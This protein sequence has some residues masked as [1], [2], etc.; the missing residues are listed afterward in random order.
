[1]GIFGEKQ[2]GNFVFIPK[3]GEKITITIVGEIKRIKN[4]DGN[5]DFNYKGKNKTTKDFYDVMDIVNEEG[6]EKQ[7]LINTWLVYFELKYTDQKE[8]TERD[9]DIGDEIEIDHVGVR[10]YKITKK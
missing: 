1:M 6:E 3:K 9:L 4:P 2:E 8:K 7:L 5:Q 10:E